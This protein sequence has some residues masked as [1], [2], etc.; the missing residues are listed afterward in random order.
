MRPN[1]RNP[2]PSTIPVVQRLEQQEDVIP[3]VIVC[4]RGVQDLEV[5][6]S[7]KDEVLLYIVDKVVHAGALDHKEGTLAAHAHAH[8]QSYS[9]DTLHGQGICC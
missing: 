9:N 3:D 4:Q 2:P 8:S 1:P 5:L 7:A 6:Q